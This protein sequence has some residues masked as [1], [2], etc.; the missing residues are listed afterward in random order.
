[1]TSPTFAEKTKKSKIT[2]INTFAYPSEEQG[3]IFDHV[4]DT[5]IREYLLALHT[6]VG[7]PQNIL[8]ASRVSGGRV[9][10]FLATKEIV[11]TFQSQHGGFSLDGKFIKTRKLKTPAIRVILSNV[12][13]IIP[14]SAIENLL[15]ES[16]GL[17][18]ISPISILRVSPTDDI[19][20][21]VVSWRRQFYLPANTDLTKIPPTI[22]LNFAE[23]SYRIF[24]TA[25]DFLCFKCSEKGHK[26]ENCPTNPLFADE[27][28]EDTAGTRLELESNNQL[29]NTEYPPLSSTAPSKKDTK[30]PPLL[31]TEKHEKSI[32]P[33]EGAE[34]TIQA[35]KRS[36]STIASSSTSNLEPFIAEENMYVSSDSDF[37]TTPKNKAQRPKKK[38]KPNPEAFL[39]PL[40]LNDS[41]IEAI[42]STI[43][44]ISQTKYQDCDFTAEKF[45]K[46]LPTVRG[47]TN[48][49]Q[50]AKSFTENLDHLH[51]VL[52]ELKPLL[53]SGTKK[54]VTSLCKA[55]LKHSS[56]SS[57]SSL[58]DSTQT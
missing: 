47:S 33:S 21:H 52:E 55:L 39:K 24:L 49:V 2:P 32:T 13:P 15:N 57:N 11:E 12:S 41:E 50:L 29:S 40:I 54:T 38:I 51:Y 46:F 20:S 17:K 35:Q 28:M 27:E 10:I 23:R 16:L 22:T 14:N 31:P 25:G 19:F 26:A 48:K 56:H 42:T 7:G 44:H 3:I 8:A 30:F 37:P 36:C 53:E 4:A 1:M 58:S 5:K 18:P 43:N 34:Q 6:S 9:I 45:I